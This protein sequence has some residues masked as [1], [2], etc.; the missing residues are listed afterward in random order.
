M[1]STVST[2]KAHGTPVSSGTRAIPLAAS[3]QT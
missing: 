2:P 3:E 1:M